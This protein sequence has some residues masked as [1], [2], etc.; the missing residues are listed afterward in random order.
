MREPTASHDKLRYRQLYIFGISE[1]YNQDEGYFG[2]D[3][4]SIMTQLRTPLI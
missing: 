2:A 1:L 3:S 4:Q